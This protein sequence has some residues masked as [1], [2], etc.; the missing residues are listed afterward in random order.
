L[1]IVRLFIFFLILLLMT[2]LS[3]RIW[4]YGPASLSPAHMNSYTQIHDSGMIQAADIPEI[5][6]ELK[7]DLDTLY[8]G[9]TF[10]TNSAGQRDNE[11]HVTKP[12]HTYRIAVLGSSWTMGSGV[13]AEDIWHSQLE[14]MLNGRANET[15]YELINFGVD[16]YS[17]GE[18]IASV[19]YK[20][21]NYDPDLIVVALTHFTPSILWQDPPPPYEGKATR[22][23]FFDLHTLRV[24]DNALGAGWFRDE[25]SR[26]PTTAGTDKFEGQMFKA[27]DRLA[28][29]SATSGVPIIIVKLAY[30]RGWGKNKNTASSGQASWERNLPYFDLT[31][32]VR[33][34]NYTAPELRISVWDSHPNPLGHKLLAKAALEVLQ[35][36]GLLEKN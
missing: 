6:Y 4:L 9:V 24:I 30:V 22:Y 2:E 26:R 25:N 28:Q 19:E 33:A 10:R 17:V 8:K 35:E 31:D 13:Q 12:D 34:N 27:Y 20:A 32:K 29:I 14:T 5:V 11:Y 15:S 3:F 16:Q 36:Q 18:I 1:Q 23:P 7:P 21:L